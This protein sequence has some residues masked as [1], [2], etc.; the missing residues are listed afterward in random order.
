MLTLLAALLAGC[1]PTNAPPVRL[2]VIVS[3]LRADHTS[4]CGYRRATTPSL[5]RLR[6]VHRA[7]FTCNA[8]ASSADPLSALAGILLDA[9]VPEHG[10]STR[11][12]PSDGAARVHLADRDPDWRAV[13]VSASPH[14]VPELTEAFD[15]VALLPGASGDQV[16]A[17]FERQLGEL[18]G[19]TLFVVHLVDPVDPWGATPADAAWGAD[20]GPLDLDAPTAAGPSLRVA[21]H[22]ATLNTDQRERM[23]TSMTDHYD[24][25][26]RAA[27]AAVGEL[28]TA[29]RDARGGLDGVRAVITG[30]AGYYLG[31]H[32]QI[33][34]VDR[35]FEPG[36]NVPIV[37][38]EPDG[39]RLP[40]IP[41]APLSNRAVGHLLARGIVPRPTPIPVAHGVDTTMSPEVDSLA[42]WWADGAKLSSFRAYPALYKLDDDPNEL[43]G[44]IPFS[45]EAWPSLEALEAP[46]AAWLA[47]REAL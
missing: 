18:R 21:W 15:T 46:W 5:E 33:G 6:T 23:L 38:V 30:D 2:L 45:H 24:H 28:L 1:G 42:L 29:V 25:G 37:L 3:G 41:S 27:D 13:L 36:V 4:L 40:A 14:A 19:P 12:G 34:R 26:V 16:V 10:L 22:E 47:A 11:R 44:K 7:T 35:L 31:E 20:R 39:G 8:R 43:R 17:E 9:S 32:L